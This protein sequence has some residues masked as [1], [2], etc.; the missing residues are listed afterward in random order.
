MMTMPFLDL[1]GSRRH[2]TGAQRLN[3]LKAGTV[4]IGL[5]M[6]ACLVAAARLCFH[7]GLTHYS[8]L[9]QTVTAT[10][11]FP[12]P[13]GLR[14]PYG[15][16]LLSAVGLA[17]L[18]IA[19]L[20]TGARARI[21]LP[22]LLLAL[23]L[24]LLLG[25]IAAIVLNPHSNRWMLGVTGANEHKV[26]WD[27]L[28]PHKSPQHGGSVD[29]ARRSYI[30]AQVALNHG[31]RAGLSEH[32]QRVLL[33]ADLWAYKSIYASDSDRTTVGT[34]RPEVIH[35]LDVALNGQPVTQV[36]LGWEQD[37]P[38]RAARTA[39]SD[40]RAVYMGALALSALCAAL[41]LLWN[42]MRRRVIEGAATLTAS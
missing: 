24:A 16:L 36:G 12:S 31:D 19:A 35:A 32:G 17:G 3:R 42:S 41:A 38:T 26:L 22:L 34:F 29:L 7:A 6:L 13:T 15:V 11:H 40:Y 30:H 5:A 9:P 1:F 20:S 28:A 8:T 37:H 2:G 27:A 25:S 23:L 18:T 4:L 39:R 21:K 14:Y 33:L 10:V